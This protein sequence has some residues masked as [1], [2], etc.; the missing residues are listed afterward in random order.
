MPHTM[1]LIA[2]R[3]DTTDSKPLNVLKISNDI[4]VGAA[5]PD[6]ATVDVVELHFPKFTDGR[7]Y[8]QAVQLRR[9]HSYQGDIR[10]TGDVLI[11]QLAQMQRTGFSSAVLQDGQDID[12]GRKLL[13]QFNGFYQG[14]AVH[15][16]PAFALPAFTQP[17]FAA[18][19]LAKVP[20]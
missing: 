5:A 19:Q 6:L 16:K 15:T 9:R 11:D 10:A 13:A 1:H 18:P 17:D 12:H 14:D 3:A 8:S 20:A 4:E 7:A 2:A